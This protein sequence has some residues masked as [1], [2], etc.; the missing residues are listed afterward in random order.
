MAAPACVF[1]LAAFLLGLA[2][3]FAMA[4]YGVLQIVL[5]N[6]DALIAPGFCGR[7]DA[8]NK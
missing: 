6:T 8:A 2:A 3:V 4:G 1:Q 5:S 7:G